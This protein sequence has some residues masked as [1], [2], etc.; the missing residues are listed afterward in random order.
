MFVL[1]IVGR[2]TKPN[3]VVQG[4]DN[5][6]KQT[7]RF[8][9]SIVRRTTEPYIVTYNREQGQIDCQVCT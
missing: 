6:N 7:S 5:Q 3:I 1:S 4:V 8:V 2:T 9:L